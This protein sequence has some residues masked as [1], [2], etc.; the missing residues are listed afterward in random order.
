M[1][2]SELESKPFYKLQNKH[3]QSQIF[4]KKKHLI[5]GREYFLLFWQV[6]F[7][8]SFHHADRIVFRWGGS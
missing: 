1:E 6:N 7:P 5:G 3:Y 8:S 2:F 4:I